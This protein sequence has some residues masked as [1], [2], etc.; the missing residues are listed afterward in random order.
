[1]IGFPVTTLRGNLNFGPSHSTY[2]WRLSQD[3]IGYDEMSKI[4]ML[5]K[6]EHIQVIPCG[7]ANS[8]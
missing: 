3:H 6:D 7:S 5:L 8:E 1:L 2:G 4:S